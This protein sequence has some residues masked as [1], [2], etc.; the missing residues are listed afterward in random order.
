MFSYKEEEE[1]IQ[2]K[3]LKWK[4]KSDDLGSSSVLTTQI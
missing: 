1:N 3:N 4:D 2:D